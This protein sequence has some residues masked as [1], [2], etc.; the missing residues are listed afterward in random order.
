MKKCTK[1]YKIKDIS[2]FYKKY[3]PSK[4]IKYIYPSCSDCC[5]ERR[6][7]DYNK[8]HKA[9]LKRRA[10]YRE[11]NRE[12]I[13]EH[14]NDKK[15]EQINNLDDRYIIK[16]L[17]QYNEDVNPTSIKNKRDTILKL[18]ETKGYIYFISCK[19]YI[20]IGF[21]INPKI[22]LGE[23]QTGN[24]FKLKIIKLLE[25]KTQKQ[26]K[27][28]HRRLKSKHPNLYKRGEWYHKDIINKGIIF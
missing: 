27:K 25:N 13:R 6:K 28:L 14:D 17:K 23:I 2:L 1:C 22:R 16:L 11:E 9:E 7:K 8:N 18:R 19:D 20:K 15:G 5:N 3:T 26:E 12:Y 21:T 4:E 24:P 10:L